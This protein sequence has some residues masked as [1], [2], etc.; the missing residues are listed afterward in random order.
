M[1]ARLSDSILGQPRV[2]VVCS[3]GVRCTC[4]VFL[5]MSGW[6][7]DSY[8]LTVTIQSLT[9]LGVTYVNFIS[10]NPRWILDESMAKLRNFGSV[11][12]A[13]RLEPKSNL[14]LWSC[15][16]WKEV[17]PVGSD[18]AKVIVVRSWIDFMMRAK[19]V[20]LRCEVALIFR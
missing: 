11:R 20:T 4:Q 5:I 12:K 17:A 7:Y 15:V 8:D 10:A 6:P 1:L 18:I 2:C 16:S 3:S 9:S 13:I 14:S 19:T